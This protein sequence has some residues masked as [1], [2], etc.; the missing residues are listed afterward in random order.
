[1]RWTIE[2]NG[3]GES[4]KSV[5]AARHDED[6]LKFNAILTEMNSKV[7]NCLLNKSIKPNGWYIIFISDL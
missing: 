3:E 1:M 7:L 2:T 4:G 6:M 5:Q